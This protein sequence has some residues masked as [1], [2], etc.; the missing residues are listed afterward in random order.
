MMENISISGNTMIFDQNADRT[1]FDREKTFNKKTGVSPDGAKLIDE[2]GEDFSLYL[3]KL[4]FS[5]ES[6]CLVLSSD[7]HFF[8]DEDEVK[9]FRTVIN[10]KKLNQIKNLDRFLHTFFHMLSPNANFI[11]CFSDD[12]KTK[13]HKFIRYETSRLFNRFINFLDSRTD[14]ILDR[15][16]V[17]ELL[18]THGFKVD[19]MTEMNGLTY[20][21]SK[22]LS[23]T[24]K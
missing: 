24:I 1:Y 10:L 18:N 19:D 14:H 9:N 15:S 13:K 21:Y 2:G 22:N 8:Y 16:K 6:N 3:K 11:G 17:S 23:R 5:K 7:H 12:K 4:N 20:F